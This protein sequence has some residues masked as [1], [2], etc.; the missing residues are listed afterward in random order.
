MGQQD[1]REDWDDPCFVCPRCGKVDVRPVIRTGAGGYCQCGA[2]RY[3]WH[4]EN[5]PATFKSPL[6]RRKSD[7]PA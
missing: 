3:V 2:C 6:R 4:I 1:G 5:V 7:P